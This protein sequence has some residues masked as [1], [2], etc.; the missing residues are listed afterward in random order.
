VFISIALPAINLSFACYSDRTRLV[1]GDP[2]TAVMHPFWRRWRDRGEE[3]QSV[4]KI[5][6]LNRT[7]IPI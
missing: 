2:V 4:S 3:W 5:S 1:R 7:P 6:C